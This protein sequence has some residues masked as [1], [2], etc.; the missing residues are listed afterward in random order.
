MKFWLFNF[1]VVIWRE[2]FSKKKV[3]KTVVDELIGTSCETYEETLE[4]ESPHSPF[5]VVLYIFFA[6][7]SPS[8]NTNKTE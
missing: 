5:K 8:S 7:T 3:G 6:S 1:V 2:E 4:L